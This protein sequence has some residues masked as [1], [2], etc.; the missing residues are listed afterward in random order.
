MNRQSDVTSEVPLAEETVFVVLSSDDSSPEA[1]SEV[2]KIIKGT[3]SHL[4]YW[5]METATFLAHD[6]HAESV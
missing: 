3:L 6:G 5:K 2:K 4:K 1:K